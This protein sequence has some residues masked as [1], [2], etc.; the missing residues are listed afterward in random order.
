MNELGAGAG[1]PT[2]K[3]MT[4]FIMPLTIPE[5]IF[6]NFQKKNGAL[7]ETLKL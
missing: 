4:F 1:Q 3:K 6:Y 2:C 5:P 7:G